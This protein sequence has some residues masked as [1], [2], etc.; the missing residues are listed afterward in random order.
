MR[1]SHHIR[2]TTRGDLSF[3]AK[4]TDSLSCSYDRCSYDRCSHNRCSRDRSSARTAADRDGSPSSDRHHIRQWH[5][6]DQF[7]TNEPHIVWH[8]L[9]ILGVLIGLP[10]VLL[11]RSGRAEVLRPV[12][13]LVRLLLWCSLCYPVFI[14]LPEEPEWLSWVA[15]IASLVL[16]RLIG[17]KFNVRFHV[18]PRGR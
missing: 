9:P 15:F 12:M 5:V 16:F 7:V 3:Q 10:L 1:R 6:R 8:Y 11:F 18:G 14:A 4:H 13:P 2:A 17:G